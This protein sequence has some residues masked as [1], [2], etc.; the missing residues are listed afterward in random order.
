[1]IKGLPSPFLHN[2]SPYEVL[3]GST[4]SYSHLRVLGCLCYASTLTRNRSK[5]DPRAK[6]CIFL[7]YPYGVKGYK[8]F[9][10]ESQIV[11]LS[12]DVVF[13]ESIFTFHSMNHYLTSHNPC[14]SSS[15]GSLFPSLLSFDFVFDLDSPVPSFPS[16]SI[17]DAVLDTNPTIDTILVTDSSPIIP[18]SSSHID[19]QPT[20]SQPSAIVPSVPVTHS[21]IQPPRHSTR[22]H[23]AP[24]YLKY[25]HYKLAITNPSP[26]SAQ[27]FPIESTLCYDHLSLPRRAFTIALSLAI[28]PTSYSFTIA[29]SLA[30]EPTSYFEAYRDPR[31]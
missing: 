11:F 8:L 16:S 30:I 3:L 27:L 18:S 31:W 20:N 15:S 24:A 13:H 25:F 23:K 14:L 19:I 4:P 12:R 22:Q 21:Q 10:L 6:P 5:F 29:L 9:D 1:M 28:E 17:L 26:S 2:K 7:G